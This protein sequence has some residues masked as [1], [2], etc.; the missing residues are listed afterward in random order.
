MRPGYQELENGSGARSYVRLDRFGDIS[1]IDV[2][3]FDCDGVLLDVRESYSKAVT[4]TMSIIVK[5]VTGYD[6]PEGLLDGRLNYAYK[7]TGGFNNDWSL[8]YAL[9]M[10][11]L[12]EL[13]EK[14]IRKLDK[15]AG[16]S[17][18]HDTPYER[19]RFLRRNRIQ[20]NVPVEQLYEKLYEFAYMLDSTGVE[21][22]DSRLLAD[23]GLNMKSALN[24]PG[25]VGESIVSTLFEEIFGGV[26]LF[27]LNYG[28]EAKFTS[29]RRGLIEKEKVVVT[30]ATIER[31][32]EL[33]GGNR[34]GIAS[35][36]PSMTGR[37]ALG[38]IIGLIRE[39]AQV[40]YDTVEEAQRVKGVENL[41][42]PSPFSLLKASEPFRPYERVLYVGDSMAD[43]LM[44][45]NAGEP[46]FLFAGIYGNMH[47]G[48][49][50]RDDFLKEHSDI[51][52]QTVNDLPEIIER[53]RGESF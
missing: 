19:F 21:A 17:L 10:R 20:A 29:N 41:H 5:A 49:E 13:P 4:R 46:E 11:I 18:K 30:E 3:V 37:Y 53:V 24:Y 39:D 38:D 12:A 32:T 31:L 52:A 7:R 40:W 15:V 22:V 44:T 35:G 45:R 23:V 47:A 14:Q 51:V 48:D 25:G 28:L 33:L 9:T 1:D 27:Q 2:V 16:E 6:L 50:V 34:I 36:S 26:D 42:K 8:T 43:R